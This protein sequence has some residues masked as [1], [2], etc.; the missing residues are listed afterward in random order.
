MKTAKPMFA[1]VAPQV[2]TEK[3]ESGMYISQLY[4]L[5]SEVERESRQCANEKYRPE[6]RKLEKEKDKIGRQMAETIGYCENAN[7][8]INI[9]PYQDRVQYLSAQFHNLGLQQHEL[10]RKVG[11]E[12]ERVAQMLLKKKG[13]EI[14]VVGPSMAIARGKIIPELAE[15]FDL[16]EEVNPNHEYN[17]RGEIVAIRHS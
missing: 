1:S 2:V 16:D 17:E 10:Y 15:Q 5:I 11:E 9:S 12:S 8:E 6:F 4:H 7:G 14:S 13:I 3:K